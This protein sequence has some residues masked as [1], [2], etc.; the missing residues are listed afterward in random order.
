MI[1]ASLIVIC[2]VFAKYFMAKIPRMPMM[3]I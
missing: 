3:I 2:V 1:D